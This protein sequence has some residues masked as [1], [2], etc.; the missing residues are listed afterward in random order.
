LSGD[1]ESSKNKANPILRIGGSKSKLTRLFNE[2]GEEYF[3][4]PENT[5]ENQ[6]PIK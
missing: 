5:E 6:E 2:S 3:H 4:V 1:N